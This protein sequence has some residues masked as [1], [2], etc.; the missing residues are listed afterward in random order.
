MSGIIRKA[1]EYGPQRAGSRQVLTGQGR[2]VAPAGDLDQHRALLQCA[3]WQRAR[4]PRAGVAWAAAPS[5]STSVPSARHDHTRRGTAAHGCVRARPSGSPPTDP[6]LNRRRPG[7]ATG[8]QTLRPRAWPWCEDLAHMPGTARA[9]RRA[10]RRR[11]PTRPPD[12]G[13]R[14]GANIA[15]RVP[16]THRDMSAAA[17]STRP[18]SAP[19]APVRLSGGRADQ[20]PAA[21]EGLRRPDRRRDGR[22][23]DQGTAS[24]GQ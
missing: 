19:A 20:S 18:C 17:P 22:D 5:R 3:A 21:T 24:C 8:Q 7:E 11:R 12:P 16:T 13:A 6:L 10:R 1:S 2:Q 4:R 14:T 15:A 9:A 23:H